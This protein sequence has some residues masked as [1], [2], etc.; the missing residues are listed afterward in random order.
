MATPSISKAFFNNL[1]EKKNNEVNTSLFKLFEKNDPNL[2][3]TLNDTPKWS[4]PTETTTHTLSKSQLRKA[5]RAKNKEKEA[6]EG[7]KEEEEEKEEGDSESDEE[8]E[9]EEEAGGDESSSEDEKTEKQKRKEKKERDPK[10]VRP[11][12]EAQ[13]TVA[14]NNLPENIKKNVCF[15]TTFIFIHYSSSS[16]LVLFFQCYY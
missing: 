7:E 2:A 11:K 13:R 5:K 4:F 3:S 10:K 9:E 1:F 6:E 8:E 14:V 16:P 15:Y 12:E